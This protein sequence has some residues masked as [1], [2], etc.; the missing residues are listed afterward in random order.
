MKK[1]TKFYSVLMLVALLSCQ[2]SEE[3]LE[4]QSNKCLITQ[5]DN[6]EGTKFSNTVSFEYDKNKNLIKRTTKYANGKI[7]IDNHKN[8]YNAENDLIK[9]T[10]TD[11]DSKLVSIIDYT[12]FEKGKIKSKI[13][14]GYLYSKSKL[15]TEYNISGKETYFVNKN[16][17]EIFERKTQ[18]DSKNNILLQE[19]IQNGN[20]QL[21]Y[22][23]TYDGNNRL[24]KSVYKG[25]SNSST[26]YIYDQNGVL[27]KTI[28]HTGLEK[29][30]KINSEKTIKETESKRFGVYVSSERFEYDNDGKLLK[31]YNSNNNKDYHLMLEYTYHPNSIPKTQKSYSFKNN[32]T[33][34]VFMTFDVVYNDKGQALTVKVFDRNTYQIGYS[35]ENKYICN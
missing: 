6:Y 5:T 32:S 27:S 28:D 31:I 4:P 11:Q 23:N 29:T 2:K 8:E 19:T 33:S 30:Y 12:Y 35:Y 13:E 21:T 25:H 22:F 18:Y 26:E 10:F 3:D 14:Q 15:T 20:V 7:L 24:L 9:V 1:F 17:N 16:G 34:E